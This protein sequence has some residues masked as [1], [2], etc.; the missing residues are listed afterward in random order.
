MAL[1]ERC[2]NK[3][4][5]GNTL[6]RTEIAYQELASSS[7]RSRFARAIW[8]ERVRGVVS[9]TARGKPVGCRRNAPLS[10]CQ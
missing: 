4:A 3:L 2:N 8:R 7:K 1:R 9:N 5:R 6:L 10:Y